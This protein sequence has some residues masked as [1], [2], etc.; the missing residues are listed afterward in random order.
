[1]YHI[2]QLLLFQVGQFE[3]TDKEGCEPVRYNYGAILS[4]LNFYV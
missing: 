1:M 2:V 3:M 4:V